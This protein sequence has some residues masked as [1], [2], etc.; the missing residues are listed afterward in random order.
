MDI[1]EEFKQK[2]IEEAD[3][4]ITNL[5]SSLLVLEKNPSEKE[6]IG[7]VF[8]VMHTLKG[9]GGMFGFN[10]ISEFTHDLESIYDLVRNGQMDL[11]PDILNTTLLSVD[12]LKV[13]LQTGDNLD[14]QTLQKHNDFTRKIEQIIHQ[15]NGK[16]IPDEP[17]GLQSPPASSSI[18]PKDQ[19]NFVTY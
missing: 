5:E 16:N 9:N 13:L 7:Q 3:E 17:A 6:H 18:Q 10:K 12:H 1:M 11:T 4:L 15:K 2:F 19:G 8:R 14:A